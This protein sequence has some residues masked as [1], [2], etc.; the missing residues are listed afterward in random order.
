[1]P[2]GAKDFCKPYQG[3]RVQTAST[4]YFDIYKKYEQ[5]KQTVI[6]DCF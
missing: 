6:F 2:S 3:E 4:C 5:S 1:M